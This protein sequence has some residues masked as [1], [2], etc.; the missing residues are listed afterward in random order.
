MVV[1]V[2]F[3]VVVVG[4]VTAR[5]RE[6]DRVHFLCEVEHR[7]AG[8]LDGFE[9]VLET[10]LQHEAVGH[11]E[12]GALHAGPILEGR[13]VPVRVAADRDDGLDLR[14][15]SAGHVGDYIGPDSGGDQDRRR[16][17]TRARGG[18]NGR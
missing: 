17:R 12:R 13:L 3:V 15:P 6:G 16:L 2:C 18:L 11:H 8:L 7:S 5:G 9:R 10:L 1:F 4:V 14:Q